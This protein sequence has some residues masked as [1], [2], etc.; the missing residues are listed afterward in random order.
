[1][2]NKNIE[3]NKRSEENTSVAVDLLISYRKGLYAIRDFLEEA[4]FELKGKSIDIELKLKLSQGISNMGKDLGKNIE[5][6]DKLEDKVR[7][8]E[9]ESVSRRGNSETSLF[10]E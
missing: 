4:A 2:S 3:V 1:M 5:S 8:E 6:L 9:R 10:E 7:R